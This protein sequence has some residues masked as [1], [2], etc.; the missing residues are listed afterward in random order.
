M[1]KFNIANLNLLQRSS[2]DQY[3]FSP[4]HIKERKSFWLKIQKPNHF[5]SF[6]ET[7]NCEYENANIVKISQVSDADYFQ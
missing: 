5:S 7:L 1:L 4:R 2:E 6:S 3:E